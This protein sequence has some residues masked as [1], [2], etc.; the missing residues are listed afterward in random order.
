MNLPIWKTE[1][2][3]RADF[4]K[5]ICP[6]ADCRGIFW[7]ASSILRD[8]GGQTHTVPCPWCFR[9]ARVEE[10]KPLKVRLRRSI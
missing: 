3:K 9:V 10:A 1:P 7:A 2:A 5:M 8:G 6:R 4:I